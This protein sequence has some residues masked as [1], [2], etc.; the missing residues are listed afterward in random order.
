[1]RPGADRRSLG[2][3]EKNDKALFFLFYCSQSVK[4]H[5]IP[6]LLTDYL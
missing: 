4:H 2:V 5:E 6:T 1:M 3:H